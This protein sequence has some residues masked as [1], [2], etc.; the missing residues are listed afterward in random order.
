MLKQDG[1]KVGVRNEV[2]A[3]RRLACNMFVGVQKA[4][5]F[6]YCP[7]MRERQERPDIGERFIWRE[8]RGK[9]PRMGGDPQI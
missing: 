2:S 9:N 4:V 8:W 5:E 3:D 6:G 1:C 7:H